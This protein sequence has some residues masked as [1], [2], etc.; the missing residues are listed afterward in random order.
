M[1]LIHDQLCPLDGS[2]LFM[3]T[4][5][6]GTF[7]R[8]WRQCYYCPRCDAGF[9]CF[10]DPAGE[11]ST[12]FT[13]RRNG[14]E[15]LLDPADAAKVSEYFQ[16][17]WEKVQSTV[18]HGIDTFLLFWHGKMHYCPSD[19]GQ[20]PLVAEL[21]YDEESTVRYYYCPSCGGTPFPFL[22]DKDSCW[23]YVFTYSDKGTSVRD[24]FRD[25]VAKVPLPKNNLGCVWNGKEWKLNTV[26]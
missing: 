16:H 6:L 9:V 24:I 23:R 21:P 22:K 1:S 20:I 2:E 8:Q 17:G 25:R 3:I 5:W 11:K 18:L 7:E 12:I 14:D 10:D 15:L 26:D 19:G 13:W 4:G